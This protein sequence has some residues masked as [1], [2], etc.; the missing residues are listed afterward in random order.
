MLNGNE[1]GSKMLLK[2]SLVLAG[3]ALMNSL[4]AVANAD[5]Q[6]ASDAPLRG[7]VVGRELVYP[8][9]VS[10]SLDAG[11]GLSPN[12]V[13]GRSS[14]EINLDSQPR[15]RVIPC[16]AG[17]TCLYA[18]DRYGGRR[19]Q[20]RDRNQVIRLSQYGF[21]DQMTSWRNRNSVDARWYYNENRFFPY[22]TSRCMNAN[23]NNSNVGPTDNDKA[24]ALRIYGSATACN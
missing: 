13:T 23:T 21:N 6:N 12:E 18:A 5:D 9:G 4:T 7:T 15:A 2:L 22:G 10:V 3:A 17:Y 8:N 1:R 11:T 14:Q 19:L 20:W 16:S 24:S